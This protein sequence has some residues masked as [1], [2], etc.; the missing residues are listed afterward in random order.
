MKPR[1]AWLLPLLAYSEVQTIIPDYFGRMTGCG[2]TAIAVKFC[3]A[4]SWPRICVM[5]NRGHEAAPTLLAPT[6]PGST[7]IRAEGRRSFS[8]IHRLPEARRLVGVCQATTTAF[9]C[10]IA[11]A[12]AIT[13]SRVP[14]ADNQSGI[15]CQ[16][17]QP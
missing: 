4:A 5:T 13:I 7:T 12:P 14:V 10:R 1:W 9:L 15:S 2:P 11:S 16:K 3:G 6:N 17:N 8:L